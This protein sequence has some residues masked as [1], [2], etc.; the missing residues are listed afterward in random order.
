M[1][2]EFNIQGKQTSFYK[3]HPGTFGYILVQGIYTFF[4]AVEEME[5]CLQLNMFMA[6]GSFVSCE[7]CNTHFWFLLHFLFLSPLPPFQ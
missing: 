4:F 6:V 1:I 2:E 5:V 7:S 3:Y